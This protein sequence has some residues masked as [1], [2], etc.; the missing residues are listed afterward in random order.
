MKRIF[1]NSFR[2]LLI[3]FSG[4]ITFKSS[5]SQ[6]LQTTPNQIK[7]KADTQYNEAGRLKRELLGKH[8]RQDWATAV[9]LEILDFDVVAGGLTPLKLGGGMQ[10]VSLR[11]KGAD[12]RE[13]VL[14][15]VKKDPSKALP[16]MLVGTIADDILQD[17]I[18]SS[19]PFAALAVASLAEAAG[20][21]H[22]S[23]KIFYVQDAKRLGEYEALFA[24]SI[25][26]LEERPTGNQED[27]AA[28]SYSKNIINS[29]KLFEK[30]Y[31]DNHYRVD[32]RSFVK[33]RLFDMWIGDWDRHEDQ[34]TW[35]EFKS[36]DGYLYQ[37]VPRDR[38]QAFAKLDGIIPQIAQQPWAI[39]K[40]KD[41]DY[42]IHDVAGLNMGGNALDRNFTTEQTQQDWTDISLELKNA[43][44]DHVIETAIKK[45]P[46]EI[47]AISGEEIIIKLKKRRDLLTKYAL[48]YYR[49]LSRE[50]NITGTKMQE[51]FKVNRIN[52]DSTEVI[53]YSNSG[54]EKKIIYKRV[55][56]TRETKEIRLYAL[57]G[58]DA[59]EITGYAEK[60][61]LVRVIG[62]QGK[63]SIVDNSVVGSMV[64][65]KTKIYDDWNNTFVTGSESKKYISTDSLKNNYNRKSFVYDWFGPKQSPGY[66][67]D[68]G[69]YIGGGLTFRKQQFGKQPYGYMHS[70][71]GNYA[72]QTGAFNFW[73]A[74]EFKEFIGKWD[75]Q[76]NAKINAP[77]YSR[78]YY[79]IGN[80][81]KMIKDDR[82]Y[83]RVRLDQEFT[84]AALARQF[85]ARHHFAVGSSFESIKVEESNN[86]FITDKNAKLDSNVFE[87]KYYAG[88]F[89]N[90]QY[91]T[92]DNQLFPR[93]GMRIK[94]GLSYA[95]DV[96][97][98]NDLIRL[99][100]ES[101]V[102]FSKG[103]WTAALR[104]GVAT[105]LND[106]FEFYQA[107]T[108]GGTENLRGFRRDRFA[109]KT[110]AYN[111]TEV[112]YKISR[113]NGYIFR[114]EY[115]LLSFVD[116][117]RVWNPG[118][119]SNSWHTGYGGGFW[120]FIYNKIPITATYGVSKED[121]IVNI[122]AGF[123][124]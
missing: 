59:F 30:I 44:T 55:F 109:G 117:G 93:K 36:G 18:S 83:Y 119:K 34:W 99:S 75:L 122:K 13:Y 24:N 113:Y 43:M 105:N 10:T 98:Q 68:D 87:R 102:F 7:A 73:Y 97:E 62:G 28:M 112:R 16:E 106:Q 89:V 54:K 32:E 115:G 41:F 31:A 47:V 82:Q 53:V 101:A 19:N 71:W 107:N 78:N 26:L 104:S 88:A 37:P 92:L 40:T 45:M 72:F 80:E 124:F 21:L 46:A 123:L 74:A 23:P 1:N 84:S 79:G 29:Q 110:S 48:E 94:A 17:Q 20:I 108:L 52:N 60:G 96:E 35:A 57:Q 3:T 116:H 38:D 39:R 50:V 4:L 66:N 77:N 121:K 111:N 100:Y 6:E 63:D 85:S 65:H 90:Y 2:L 95:R 22:N 61:I 12:G 14:R 64:L 11:L 103:K 42:K 81:T 69:I 76:L 5:Y 91:N 15:S 67:P 49:F 51:S 25:C 58:N 9:Q 86:R 56:L 118:E 33:A 8:Y 27:N 120:L 70:V 114:G